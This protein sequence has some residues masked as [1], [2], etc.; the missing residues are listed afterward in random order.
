MTR[1]KLC[2]KVSL[3]WSTSHA[4]KKKKKYTFDVNS[5]DFATAEQWMTWQHGE[6]GPMLGQAVHF[7][8]AAAG[9]FAAGTKPFRWRLRVQ[10]SGKIVA[11]RNR[12]VG[13]P[14]QCLNSVVVSTPEPNEVQVECTGRKACLSDLPRS[15]TWAKWKCQHDGAE[16]GIVGT[17]GPGTGCRGRCRLAKY[18]SRKCRQGRR[19]NPCSLS[20]LEQDYQTLFRAQSAAWPPHISL[21]NVLQL[22]MLTERSRGERDSTTAIQP[23]VPQSSRLHRMLGYLLETLYL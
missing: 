12:G 17:H 23:E 13:G 19:G 22:Q 1:I 5:L 10:Y 16:V 2:W 3:S 14:I 8:R 18:R 20:G 11:V 7:Y 21:E 6:I 9:V 4:S 15:K